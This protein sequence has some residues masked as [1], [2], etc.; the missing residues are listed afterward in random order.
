VSYTFNNRVPTQ[1]TLRLA[2]HIIS[3]RTRYD[4][5]YV[6]DQWTI[7][8]LTLNLGARFN[9]YNASIPEQ[10]LPEG[11]F[12]AARRFP[13]VSDSPDWTNLDLRV[14]AAYNLFGDGRTAV[15]VSLGRYSPWL[16]GSATAAVNN[17]VATQAN[18]TQRTW[19]DAN[20]NYAP[21]CDLLNPAAHGE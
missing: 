8:N 11:P 16:P 4:G 18:S 9:N 19:N 7:R 14:G 12:V 5:F 6:Q 3:N 20:G 13:A 15:K 2:P 10:F 21:D 17:P 1:F